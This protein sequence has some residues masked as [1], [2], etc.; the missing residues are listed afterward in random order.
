MS[1]AHRFSWSVRLSVALVALWSVAS[2]CGGSDAVSSGTSTGVTVA[3]ATPA[4]TSTSTPTPTPSGTG[5]AASDPPATTGSPEA[6]PVLPAGEPLYLYNVVTDEGGGMLV[7]RLDGTDPVRLGTD[8]TGVHKHGN[9]SPDGG[10]VVFID[11]ET[12]TM[13]IAHLDGTASDQVPGCDH[14]GC[15]YP[16]FSPDGSK[17]AYSRYQDGAGV[18]GP[19]SVGVEVVDLGSGVVTEVVRLARPLLAD[20]PRWSADGTQLVIGVD[21]MD[22]AAVETGAAVAVVPATGGE[23]AYLT[24]FSSFGYAPDWNV[25][26]DEIVFSTGVRQYAD[27][28]EPDEAWDAWG[29]RPDGTMLRRITHAEPGEHVLGAKWV[30]DGSSILALSTTRGMVSIDPNTGAMTPL[31]GTPASVTSPRLRPLP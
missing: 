8:V 3:T 10:S 7:T 11:D 18:V 2:G 15:D 19:A 31:S 21:Q 13:W 24:D 1:C 5:A 30:P 29:V 23:P 22:D 6:L 12:E 25:S 26:T 28:V 16:A 14:D 27:D 9:W 20:V 4:P 17:I